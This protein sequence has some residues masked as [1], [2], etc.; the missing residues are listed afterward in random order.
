MT[1]TIQALEQQLAQIQQ[2]IEHE[3][4]KQ[5]VRDKITELL[6]EAGYT[7]EDLYG[8]KKT[9]SPSGTRKS[10]AKAKYQ[11]PENL[12]K[13]WSGNNPKPKWVKE[14]E[15]KGEDIEN[16]RIKGS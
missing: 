2:E 15:A 13:T 6:D 16:Y 14:I 11:H 10:Y 5:E 7:F 12:R 3:K 4:G 9:T 1:D 8:T